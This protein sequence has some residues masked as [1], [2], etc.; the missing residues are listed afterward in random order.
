MRPTYACFIGLQKAFNRVPPEALFRKLQSLG[1]EGGCLEFYRGLYRSSWTQ[2]S[3]RIPETLSPAFPFCRGADRMI[4][5]HLIC[6]ISNHQWHWYRETITWI[7]VCR[8]CGIFS[9]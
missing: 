3:S 2:V 9:A 1:I 8:L 4:L 7:D 6:P 5:H